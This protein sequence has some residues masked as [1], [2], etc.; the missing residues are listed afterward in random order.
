MK[1][2]ALFSQTGSE[3]RELSKAL[4]DEPDYIYT[5]NF[6]TEDW[7]HNLDYVTVLNHVDIMRKIETFD[8]S[9]V[10]ITLHGYLRIIPPEICNEYTIYNGHP[11]LITHYPQL[12]GKDPQEKIDLNTM[13]YLGSVCHRVTAEV[14]S[15]EI[16]TSK[17]VELT[18]ESYHNRYTVLKQ[19]SLQAWIELF[20]KIGKKNMYE[21]EV[22]ESGETR[23]SHYSQKEGSV[24]CIAVI[25]QL[26]EEHQNDTFTDYNR[27][28]CMK[29]LWR[30][31]QK[32]DVLLE[33]KKAKQFLD[34]AIENLEEKRLIEGCKSNG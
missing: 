5:N 13:K 27:Y 8:P 23:P 26:C 25:K 9:E 11:G 22:P 34:F 32:D 15:G 6:N 12:K 21:G 4:N 2:V 17:H 19:T 24:E 28:Q 1:W 29:Y 20:D 16:L 33:L 31:G 14:D 7:W 3:I 18:K 10:F 30:L